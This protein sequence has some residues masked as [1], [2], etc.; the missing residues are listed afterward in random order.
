MSK[1]VKNILVYGLIAAL[2]VVVAVLSVLLV[3]KDK[4]NNGGANG[5]IKYDCAYSDRKSV[6]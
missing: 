6:V 2:V 3:K 1:L 5:S 4:P